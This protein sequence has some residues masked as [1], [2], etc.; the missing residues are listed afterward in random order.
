MRHIVVV[1]SLNMDLVTQAERFAAP[2]ETILGQ[3]FKTFM[4]GKGA[5]QAVASARLGARVS[6]IGAV[7][8]DAFG[9]EL[10]QGLRTEGV[11]TDAVSMLS[12]HH[13]GIASITVA[14]ADNHIIVV[15]GANHALTPAHIEAQRVLIHSA[16]AVLC[17]L[18]IPL[19][20]V[21]RTAELCH[22]AQVP[23]VLNP[24]PAQSLPDALWP[25]IDYL[26]PNEHE[27]ALMSPAPKDADLV[28]QLASLSCTVI[29]T[30]GQDGAYY[31]TAGSSL[32][33]QPSFKVKAIDSTGAGDTF[34]AALAVYLDQGLPQAVHKACAAGAL[35]VTQLG[36]QAGMPSAD[37]LTEFI[38]TSR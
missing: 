2:G 1:G 29:M 30:H 21:Q 26:T 15:P 14:A 32:Q 10:I 27:L 5:N 3:Q 18:E 12:Q 36:A 11:D 24:A 7:G 6:L 20:T 16:D 23:F 35:A 38:H 13:T 31:L 8:D 37:A 34:N 19:A 33:H 25:L 4:G 9:H 28:T 22:E 17:Q